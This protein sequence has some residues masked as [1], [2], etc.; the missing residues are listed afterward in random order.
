MPKPTDPVALKFDHFGADI[1]VD[2]YPTYKYLRKNCP[3]GWSENYGGFWVVT[4]YDDINEVLHKPE[5]FSSYP[6]AIPA[7]LGQP[8]KMIPLEIDPP[9]HTTYRKILDP[10]FGPRII[11]V[12]EDQA[13]ELAGS[14]I[15]DMLLVPGEVD[16]VESFAQDYPTMLFCRLVGFP[17]EKR[18]YLIDQFGKTIHI[19]QLMTEDPEAYKAAALEIGMGLAPVFYELM[20]Q[21]RDDPKED[22][23]GL[24]TTTKKEGGVPL[25][26]ME[27]LGILFTIGV[28]GLETVKSVL[29]N[30][31]SHLGARSDLRDQIVAD[32]TIIP[33]AV[34]EMLRFESPVNNGRTVVQDVIIN[35]QHMR[36]GDRVM[37]ITGSAG[38]DESK[39]DNPD[40]IHL[41]RTPN[42]HLAFVAGRHRCL[43]SHLARME[44]R[45]AFEEIHR[46]MPT[47][48]IPAGATIERHVSF[49][50]G[51]DRLPFLTRQPA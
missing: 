38:R 27:I 45:V 32:P 31:F 19:G 16:F 12:L 5:S 3:V 11:K 46:R 28:A 49:S 6:N 15:D 24:L 44:L 1:A 21:S 29:A 34:E 25:D 41:G 35:G 39:F 51:V 36:E 7:E 8:T 14:L 37:L 50:R 17:E 23:T 22:L 9:E 30:S 48:G 4:R 20:Q 47:Y 2:P 26:D 18:P 42:N 43:G 33:S 10:Y 40:E 13:R